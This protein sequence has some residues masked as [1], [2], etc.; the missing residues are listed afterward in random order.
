MRKQRYNKAHKRRF[1]KMEDLKKVKSVLFN[2]WGNDFNPQISPVKF[3]DSHLTEEPTGLFTIFHPMHPAI[4]DFV[5]FKSKDCGKR[6][7]IR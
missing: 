2:V 3:F 7:S 1:K 5:S 4:Y 6:T